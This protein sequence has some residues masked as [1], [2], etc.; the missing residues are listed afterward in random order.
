MNGHVNAVNK[1][2]TKLYNRRAVIT[3]QAFGCTI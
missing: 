1:A 2:G 3:D